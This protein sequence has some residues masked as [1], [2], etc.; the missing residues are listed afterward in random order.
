MDHNEAQAA[1]DESARRRQQTIDAG[2]APWP[3]RTVA[4]LAGALVVLGLAVDADM[5]WLSVIVFG[6][7]ALVGTTRVVALR[8][9]RP[10][11]GWAAVLLGTFALAVLADIAVQFAVRGADLTFPNTWGA[12]AA[13]AVIVV[14]ARPV[15]ARASASLRP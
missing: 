10:S 15:Q 11:R 6:G 8:S 2:T 4:A 9:T 3:W 1:L 13:A 7:L 5:I 14:L 12:A